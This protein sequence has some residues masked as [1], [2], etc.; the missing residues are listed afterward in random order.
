MSQETGL[1]LCYHRGCGKKFD[2]HNNK[3][4]D[5]IYH[6]GQPVFHDAYKGWSCCSKKCTDFTEFLNIKG[7]TKSKHSNEKPLEPEKPPVDRHIDEKVIQVNL[8]PLNN[9]STLKRPS[10]DMPQL[11][12]SPTISPALLEEANALTAVEKDKPLDNV[13]QIG[14]TCQ[15]NSCQ[16][17]YT[18]AASNQEVCTYHPGAPIFHE[19]LKF[20]AC[21]CKRTTEFSTFL[22]QPGCTQGKHIW[23]PKNEKK[24][25]C[26]MDWHQTGSHIVVSVFAKK[27]LPSQS[28]V[29]LNPIHLTVQLFFLKEDSRYNLDIELS[30]IVDVEQSS[31]HMLPTKVEIKLKK[32]EPG[33]WSKLDVPIEIKSKDSESNEKVMNLNSQIEAVD[34]S[35]L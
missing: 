18:G 25:Q 9:E 26:R 17:T 34:L 35:D 15:N 16:K 2:P 24:A 13:V 3:D 30:K 4:D 31:V 12:L 8:K 33:S 23:L 22:N 5:C 10:F 6:P 32:A 27:Y 21:C 29:K 19:G 7:C 11:T 14:Q 1:L 28:F 20:W